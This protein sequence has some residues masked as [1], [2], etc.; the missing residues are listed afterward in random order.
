MIN[1]NFVA[2]VERR[3]LDGYIEA[4][5]GLIDFVFDLNPNYNNYYFGLYLLHV[6]AIDRHIGHAHVFI[7][8]KF[9]SYESLHTILRITTICIHRNYKYLNKIAQQAV[10]KTTPCRTLDALNVHRTNRETNVMAY[11]IRRQSMNGKQ[12]TA[13][14]RRLLLFRLE[15]FSMNICVCVVCIICLY[16]GMFCKMFSNYVIIYISQCCTFIKYNEQS[17]CANILNIHLLN[18]Q[19]YT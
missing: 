18:T 16:A 6:I 4:S 15:I 2:F 5:N 19:I 12:F 10:N 1:A 11:S 3:K 13:R 7:S 8:K 14:Y 17:K 9:C